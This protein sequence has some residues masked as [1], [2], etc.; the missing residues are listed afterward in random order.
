MQHSVR[1][2][3]YPRWVVRTERFRALSSSPRSPSASLSP[4]T[5]LLLHAFSALHLPWPRSAPHSFPTAPEPLARQR[6]PPPPPRPYLVPTRAEGG[7]SC[8]RL[9]Q[10]CRAAAAGHSLQHPARRPA[11]AGRGP[12][13]PP[14]ARETLSTLFVTPDLKGLGLWTGPNHFSHQI[15]EDAS[16]PFAPIQSP[17]S[18]RTSQG[19]GD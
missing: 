4:L 12:R 19:W 17:Q 9:A 13:P 8:I 7:R 1:R 6:P 18:W 3:L 2:K 10:T 16:L 5:T 15:L 11:R 14:V